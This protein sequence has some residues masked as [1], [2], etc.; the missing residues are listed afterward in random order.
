MNDV[1]HA[2][3]AID[4]VMA[5]LGNREI[6]ESVNAV[7][8]DLP[9]SA[10][11]FLPALRNG[12]FPWNDV[13]EPRLW[14]SPDPRAVLFLD[15]FHIARSL[16]KYIRQQR[17]EVTFDRDFA[18]TVA[19]CAN[20]PHTWLD[21]ELIS[22]L[23]ELH[24]LGIAHSVESWHD[25]NLVGGIYGMDVDG[26]F[27]GDSMFTVENNASKVALVHLV[28]RLKRCGFRFMDCQVLNE[29]TESLGA[30]NISRDEFFQLC[31]SVRQKQDMP[32]W[33]SE[34]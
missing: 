22:V 1:A 18:G 27:I 31:D 9:L 32:F 5:T 29:H 2:T 21:P 4:V 14:W 24:H 34:S 17:F 28:H 6:W 23:N 16:A 11:L 3:E 20:R 19:G 15:E 12:I 10:E 30:R 33:H 26:I 13:N 25:G 8:L 7:Q